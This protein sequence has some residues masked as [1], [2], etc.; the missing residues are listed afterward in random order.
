MK[1]YEVL[2]TAIMYLN[3][4]DEIRVTGDRTPLTNKKLK[5][6][7][8]C[9]NVIISEI[10]SDYLPLKEKQIVTVIDNKV[11]YQSFDRRVIDVE[12]VIKDDEIIPFTVYPNYLEIES[13]GEVEILYHYLPQEI[14]L[15]DE[16]PYGVNLSPVTLAS[17]I[18]AEYSLVNNMYEEALSFERKFKEGLINNMSSPKSRY[19]KARRWL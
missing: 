15:D 10:A 3:L 5:T 2:D 17:G 16:V 13:E 19:I 1:L 8:R 4:S 14:S 11:S 12:K 6:L 7:I 18:A 9:A